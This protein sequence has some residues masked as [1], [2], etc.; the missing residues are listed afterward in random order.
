MALSLRTEIKYLEKCV[1]R[2][3]SFQCPAVSSSELHKW[4]KNQPTANHKESHIKETLCCIQSSIPHD[5]P[6]LTCTQSL[7]QHLMD[8]TP[9]S[10]TSCSPKSKHCL[11][12]STSHQRRGNF[13]PSQVEARAASHQGSR[14]LATHP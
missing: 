3:N 5:S 13:P 14:C 8:H 12:V 10:F 1:F 2:K 11:T 9:T 7:S 4:P 6:Q